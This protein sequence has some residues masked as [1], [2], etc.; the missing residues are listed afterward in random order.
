MMLCFILSVFNRPVPCFT[1]HAIGTWPFS[2]ILGAFS[3]TQKSTIPEYSR[4][5]FQISSV[6]TRDGFCGAHRTQ[7]C[8]LMLMCYFCATYVWNYSPSTQQ[9]ALQLVSLWVGWNLFPLPVHPSSSSI[10]GLGL[11]LQSKL[12]RG[13]RWMFMADTFLPAY[14]PSRV[15]YWRSI[16][17]LKV[18]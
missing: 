7:K 2:P 12:L 6:L 14:V 5:C 9:S 8:L 13:E 17:T 3:L 1:V 18:W 11:G 15:L 10:L 16:S 4:K